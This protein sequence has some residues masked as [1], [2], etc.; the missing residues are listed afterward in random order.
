LDNWDLQATILQAKKTFLE[1]KIDE[2]DL[3]II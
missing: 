2:R 1:T 3:D